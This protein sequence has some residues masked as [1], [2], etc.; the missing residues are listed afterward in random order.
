MEEAIKAKGWW[1][2]LQPPPGQMQKSLCF[3]KEE[4]EPN[5]TQKSKPPVL[6]ASLVGQPHK[7]PW[8]RKSP[9][10]QEVPKKYTSTETEVRG[11]DLWD[12]RSPRGWAQPAGLHLP[13]GPES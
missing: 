1:A 7:P 4:V 3:L 5:P 10:P 13:H 9:P 11:P 2:W 6:L 8:E 12:T